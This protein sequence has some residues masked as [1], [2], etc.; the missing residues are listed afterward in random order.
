MREEF[1][2]IFTAPNPELSRLKEELLGEASD[3]ELGYREED[4][5]IFERFNI[6]TTSF[7]PED[8]AKVTS[9]TDLP[10]DWRSLAEEIIKSRLKI[11]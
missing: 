1:K 2:E 11:K 3:Y 4:G 6:D 10:D 7:T 9:I 8:V 5:V